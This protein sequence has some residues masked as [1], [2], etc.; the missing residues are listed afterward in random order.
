MPPSM[1][2]HCGLYLA[3]P[4]PTPGWVTGAPG[5]NAA[6]R[7]LRDLW[8]ASGARFVGTRPV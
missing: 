3:V 8:Q 7:I 4:V 2:R 5:H 6:R 1:Q